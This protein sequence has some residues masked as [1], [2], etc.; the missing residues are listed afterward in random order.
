MMDYFQPIVNLLRT[1][2]KTKGFT[3]IIRV[4][5]MVWQQEYKGYAKYPVND[6]YNNLGYAVHWYPGWYNSCSGTNMTVRKEKVTP[7]FDGLE[8]ACGKACFDWY[9][10]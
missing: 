1:N 10:E 2:T 7:A 3:G 5:G 6:P 9:K 8:E 4:P